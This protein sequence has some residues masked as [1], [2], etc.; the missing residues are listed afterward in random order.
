VSISE[1]RD[2]SGT[3]AENVVTEV[4]K[5][6]QALSEISFHFS[7]HEMSGENHTTISRFVLFVDYLTLLS[8][9]RQYHIETLVQYDSFEK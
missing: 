1:I 3:K 2:T 6:Y 9:A 8:G 5:N 7:C 4:S